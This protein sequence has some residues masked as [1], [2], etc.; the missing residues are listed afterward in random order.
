V[1]LKPEKKPYIIA[2][3]PIGVSIGDEDE[4]LLSIDWLTN[5]KPRTTV[6]HHGRSRTWP[7]H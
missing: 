1:P 7:Q 6:E 4:H 3:E 2:A 5:S